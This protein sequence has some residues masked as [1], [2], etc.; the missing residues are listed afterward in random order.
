MPL[1]KETN[2]NQYDYNCYLVLL[3]EPPTELMTRAATDYY[4]NEF[5]FHWVPSKLWLYLE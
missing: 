4:S 3:V 1:N 5:D 2:P